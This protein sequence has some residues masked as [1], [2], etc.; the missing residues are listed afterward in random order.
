MRL[1]HANLIF[2]AEV[3]LAGGASG[4]KQQAHYVNSLRGLASKSWIF[5]SVAVAILKSP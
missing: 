5:S 1:E 4:G 2:A 3:R